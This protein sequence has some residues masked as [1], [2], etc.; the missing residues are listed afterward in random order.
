MGRTPSTEPCLTRH[1][2]C[3]SRFT[4]CSPDDSREADERAAERRL[5]DLRGRV[6]P[7]RQVVASPPGRDARARRA[8]G[9][10]PNEM[11]GRRVERAVSTMKYASYGPRST[12]S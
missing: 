10:G 11:L 12:Q 7:A 9:G 5:R 4:R 1:L 6:K 8:Q 2:F 3:K